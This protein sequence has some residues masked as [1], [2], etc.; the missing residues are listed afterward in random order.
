MKKTV[1][2][3]VFS[4]LTMVLFAQNK[5]P[6]AYVKPLDKPIVKKDTLKSTTRRKEISKI[7]ADQSTTNSKILEKE[8][9]KLDYTKKQTDKNGK[10]PHI[11]KLEDPITGK[12]PYLKKEEVDVNGKKAGTKRQPAYI[13]PVERKVPLKPKTTVGN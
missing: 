5:L 2:F 8:N 12:N 7:K 9:V 6:A 1:L 13:K 11:K 3:L 10:N 4:I